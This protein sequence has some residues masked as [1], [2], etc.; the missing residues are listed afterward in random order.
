M[1][2]HVYHPLLTDSYIRYLQ[3]VRDVLEIM[4]YSWGLGISANQKVNL[5]GGR[6]DC[7]IANEPARKGLDKVQ[8]MGQVRPLLV[9]FTRS[10]LKFGNMSIL[11]Q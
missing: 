8:V 1:T 9:S 6:I 2:S 11:Q 10:R 5:K 3:T 4:I 7:P